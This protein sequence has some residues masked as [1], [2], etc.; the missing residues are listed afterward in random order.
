[1]E[2]TIWL[3]V[4]LPVIL[5]WLYRLD[6]RISRIETTLSLLTG[7]QLENCAREAPRKGINMKGTIQDMLQ[8]EK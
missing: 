4:C 2:I 1:M 3:N 6:K 7:I 5:G 8:R